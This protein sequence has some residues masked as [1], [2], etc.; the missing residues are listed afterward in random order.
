[1]LMSRLAARSA[2]FASVVFSLLAAQSCLAAQPHVF[3]QVQ[4]NAQAKTTLSGRLLVFVK[5]GHGDKQITV[6]EFHP[7]DTWIAAREVSNVVPGATVELDADDTA[8]PQPFK[9]LPAG[10]YEAQAVLDVDRG[11]NYGGLDSKAWTSGVL[12]LPAWR[13]GEGAE[14]I[15]TL[16]AEKGDD[17]GDV[18]QMKKATEAARGAARLEEFVS[19]QL[20][21]FWGHPVKIRAWVVLPPG[22]DA[23]ASETYPT[24]YWTHGFGGALDSNLM[25]GLQIHTRMVSAKLPPMLWVMLDESLAQ[26]TH[27]FCDSVNNGPWGTALTQEFIPYLEQR[28][29]MDARKNGRFLNG[30]SSGGWATLQ[31]QVNYPD[32]FGGTWSTSPDPSDFH[33]FT[34]VDLYAANANMY[35]RAD[36]SAYPIF[37]D[38]GKVI[39]TAEQFSRMEAV[40]GPY[41]GQMASFDWVFSPKGDSGAPLPMF[42]RATGRVNPDVIA[43]WREHYD[44]AHIVETTWATRGPALKG[45]IHLIVGTADSFYLD[46]AAHRFEAVLARLGADARFEY[47]EGKTHFNLYSDGSDSMALLTKIAAEMEKV[48]RP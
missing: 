39:A 36:G 25:M 45:R 47:L 10:D 43:Y 28:Y 26:G 13:P 4:L 12:A 27:E 42:D 2:A 24:V 32:I 46:G 1:M 21:R 40:I 7:G 23:N 31:L 14:P 29:R 37:L 17:P 33:D 6:D 41:G 19:P 15:L 9:A 35:R 3:F 16:V 18:E 30:H 11:F 20:S 38:K 22:Y 34:G 5:K 44:L 48:A 8:Y